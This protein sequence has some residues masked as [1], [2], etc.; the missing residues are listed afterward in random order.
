LALICCPACTATNKPEQRDFLNFGRD[1]YNMKNPFKTANT[2]L[3]CTKWTE[4]VGF[5]R[6]RL[7]LPVNFA[8]EWFF[9]FYLT[10]GSRLSIADESR[11][12][13]KSC[14]GM[15]ITLAL[16]TNAI[17]TVW[18]DL[19]E[20]A[21]EPTEIKEHP[22]GARVFYLYDPEGHRIEIWQAK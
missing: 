5:Y 8:N 10:D 13:V 18:A 11:A 17:E 9:E 6:D 7:G 22:W 16:E 12:S 21:L 2:I 15:G 3:Y 19:A 20:S 14:S 1:E 4:T